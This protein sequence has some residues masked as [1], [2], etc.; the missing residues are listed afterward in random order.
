MKKQLILATAGLTLVVILFVFGKTETKK[1]KTDALMPQNAVKSFNITQY[2]SEIRQKLT[3]AQNITLGKLENSV[4]RGDIKSQQINANNQLASYW[5]DSIRSLEPYLYYLSEAA[6]LDNSEKNLTFAAQL[7]LD[8]LKGE[9]DEVK[10]N[11][12]AE[13]AIKLFEQALQLNPESND[14]KIGLGSCYIYGKGHLGKPEETMK[15]IQLLLSVVRKDSANMK[16]Q[17]VLGVGGYVSGQFD[18]AIDRLQKV[19]HSEPGN[20]EA[21]AYLA[22]TYA[23]KGNKEEA[24]KWYNVLKKVANNPDYAKQINERIKLLQEDK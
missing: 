17:L 19:I 5:K 21:I 22:D 14:L 13:N 8:N 16:A 6:K 11:W 3:P 2:I 12:E 4:S 1:N 10:L 7:I 15:G 20:M 23:S 9:Q 24:I 18:K